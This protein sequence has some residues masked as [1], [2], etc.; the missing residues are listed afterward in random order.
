M[1]SGQ[2]SGGHT[3]PQCPNFAGIYTHDP[4]T[5]VDQN[6]SIIHATKTFQLF[7][8]RTATHNG[9][10]FKENKNPQF[11]N[12]AGH[13]CILPEKGSLLKQ[14][15]L[16]FLNFRRRLA[17]YKS[18]ISDLCRGLHAFASIKTNQLSMQ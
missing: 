14:I 11:P 3:N 4:R 18:T 1:E 10:K 5:L 15:N 12:F 7:K 13:S 2:G 17:I 6:K 8:L 16:N 9:T